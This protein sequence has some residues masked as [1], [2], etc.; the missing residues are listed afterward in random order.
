MKKITSVLVGLLASV[1]SAMATPIVVENFEGYPVGTQWKMWDRWGNPVTSTAEVI[2]DPTN[3]NNKILK[4]TVKGW[5]CFPEFPVPEEYAGKKIK[6]I[7]TSV[8]FRMYRPSTD[9]NDY[10]QLHVFFGS[11]VQYDCSGQYPYQGDRN[12]WQQR[13]YD[14]VNV[15]EGSTATALR[16]G[17]HCDISEYYLDD[18]ML[19]GQ[20]DD[21]KTYDS[22][23]LNICTKNSS[24]SYTVYTTPTFIPEG[25][26]LNVYTSRY[27]DFNAP[28]AGSGTLNIYGGGERTYL[29]EHNNKKYPDWHLFNG[30]VHIYPY[31]AV[32]GSA[33]F[34]GVVMAT[35]GKTFSPEDIDNCIADGKACDMLRNNRV[36]LHNGAAMAF[37]NGTRAAQYGELNTEA[38]SRIYGYYKATAG[39]GAYL[40]VGASNT[41]AIMAGRIAPMESSGKPLATCLVGLIKDGKGTYTITANDNC[42]SGAL[43][44]RDGRVDIC[45]DAVAA[46][47]SKLSGGTGTPANNNAVAFVLG[48]GVLGG[49]GNIAGIVDVYGTLEPG[50]A[51]KCGTLTMKDYV[52]GAKT[53]LRMHPGGMLRFKIR[54]ADDY[55]RLVVASDIMLSNQTEDFTTSE[56][57]PRVKIVLTEDYDVKVGDEFLL[58]TATQRTDADKWKWNVSFPSKLS[59][60]IEERRN[61]DGTYSLL[62]TVTSLE[63]DPGNTGGDDDND[64]KDE[65]DEV[66]PESFG[67]DGSGK[68]LRDYADA[69]RLHIGVAVP[70]SRLDVLN[71]SD[72]YAKIIRNEFNMVVTENELKFDWVEPS[73]NTFNYADGDRLLSVAEANGMLMRGHTLAWHSQ[74][75]SWVSADGKKNDKGW[76]KAQLMDILKN[77]IMNVVGHYKGRIAVWDV[78]NECLDDDQSIVRSNPDGYKLRQQSI[79][80]TVCGEEFID[81]AFVWAHRADPSAILYLNE[82]GNETMGNAKAQAFYNLAKRLKNSGIPIHGVGLQSHLDAGRVNVDG[83]AKNIARFEPLG[84]EC[85]LTELDLGIDTDTEEDR[86]LQAR[87]YYRLVKAAMLQPNCRSVLVWGISDNM[88][89]RMSNP[90]LW[91]GA[92]NKKPAYFGVREALKYVG[93]NV[94]TG[95][96]NKDGQVTISD[97]NMTVNRYLGENVNGFFQAAADVN[98]DK[99]I[100]IADANGMINIFLLK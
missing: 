79:W 39:T 27:T 55:D 93:E 33:G 22:Q 91:N 5:N 23:E 36:F 94:L 67:D 15:P 49:T 13:S 86:Q 92:L 85:T 56:E 46:Q 41:D 18:I 72:A 37:E 100:T 24:S 7:F 30:D 4:V 98:N 58:L 42:I 10:K 69:S 14:I 45:N 50:T 53:S 11:D 51:T 65:E 48:K 75:A 63:D 71:L 89:W 90:L 2:A 25:K 60:K 32:E 52:A 38:G 97:A 74:V 81:S 78:V 3:A 64:K 35:N 29:G 16:L 40:I 73:Q 28:F 19:Y 82:Y 9:N 61:A 95:D 6:D 8:R 44:V 99:R 47:K 84:L 70:V 26:Y 54:S 68:T 80:T 1:A 43:R 34:Y 76:S 17:I 87:D 88:S 77:H 31:K 21:Y 96:V 83:I 66:I 12:V 57:M 59:W 20:F 62:L